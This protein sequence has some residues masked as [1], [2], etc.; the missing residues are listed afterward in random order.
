MM[1]DDYKTYNTINERLLSPEGGR[2]TRHLP[3]R[4]Y[5]PLPF[6][7]SDET[8]ESQSEKKADSKKEDEQGGAVRILQ[9]LVP[10]SQSSRESS[11]HSYMSLRGRSGAKLDVGEPN[12]LGTMLHTILP[13]LFPSRRRATLARPVMHGAVVPLGAPVEALYRVGAGYDGW[14]SVVIDML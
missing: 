4:F 14:A 5:L 10:P 2:G 12:T 7:E 1:I 9:P 6:V 3:I 8:S 13:S 11:F